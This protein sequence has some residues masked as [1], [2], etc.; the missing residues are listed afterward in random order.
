MSVILET[1]VIFDDRGKIVNILDSLD[2]TLTQSQTLITKLRSLK[3]SI[4]FTIIQNDLD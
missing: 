3:S 1:R 2:T 4:N